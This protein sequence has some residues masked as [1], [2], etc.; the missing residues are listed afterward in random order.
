MA[1]VT[2]TRVSDGVPV[3]VAINDFYNAIALEKGVDNVNNQLRIGDEVYILSSISPDSTPSTTEPRLY[4]DGNTIKMQY[5]N[6]ASWIDTG[7]SWDI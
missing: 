2:V 7:T 5:Y 4:K 3:Q 1:T 6:G